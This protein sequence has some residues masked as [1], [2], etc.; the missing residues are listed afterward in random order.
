MWRT[1]AKI[2][3]MLWRKLCKKWRKWKKSDA[4]KSLSD[5]SEFQRVPAICAKCCSVIEM[6]IELNVGEYF[7]DAVA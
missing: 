3:T 2:K 1:S 7:V 5:Q 4:L 6:H